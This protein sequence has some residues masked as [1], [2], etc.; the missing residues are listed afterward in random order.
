M[1]V[2]LAEQEARR[3]V[4]S[5]SGGG[6]AIPVALDYTS[7]ADVTDVH[8]VELA[9]VVD[10]VWLQAHNTDAA[11][12]DLSIVLNP[13]DDT[14]T[15]AIDAVTITVTIPGKDSLWVLQGDAFRLRGANT[16]TITAYTAT[17]DVDKIL[18]TGYVVRA[19]GALLY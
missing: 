1:A 15:A 11:D 12:V 13:S 4:L 6:G 18:L 2:T 5:G 19:K 16:T 3:D 17:A 14:S 8:H 10:S 9:D 7:A